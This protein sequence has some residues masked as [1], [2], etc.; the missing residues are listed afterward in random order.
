MT[1]TSTTTS[2]RTRSLAT[3]ALGCLAVFPA[4]VV[5]LNIVQRAHYSTTRQAMSELALGRA[6]GLMTVAFL[7]MGVG[8]TLVAVVLRRELTRAVVAPGCLVLAGLLDGVS[9]FFHTNGENAASTTS[10][11]VHMWAGISTFLLVIVAMFASVRAMRRTPGWSGLA[12]ATLV[13]A[14]LAFATFFLVPGLGD[15]RFGLAQRIF[16]AVWL[17]WLG[18]VAVRA[19]RRTAPATAT[20]RPAPTANDTALT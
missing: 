7:A 4:I 20:P 17:T 1:T 6:G 3:A 2:P 10:S 15:A 19:R 18:T 8:T 12:T 14:C 11:T 5:L 16:V 9:A 13:W